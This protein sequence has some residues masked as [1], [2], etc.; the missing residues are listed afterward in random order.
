MIFISHILAILILL[1]FF[2]VTNPN[3][4]FLTWLF[5]LAIDFDEPIVVLQKY[6]ELKNFKKFKNWLKRKGSPKRNWFDESGGLVVSLLISVMIKN[7]V[8]FLAN[9]VHCIM[10]WSCD[11]ESRPL[12]PFYNKLRTRGPFKSSFRSIGEKILI[13]ILAI[14][15]IILW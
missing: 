10:D 4:I 7:Y 12:A 9:L 15:L 1:R 3:I 11:F 14:I 2:H 8:P 6:L 13:I 5:G